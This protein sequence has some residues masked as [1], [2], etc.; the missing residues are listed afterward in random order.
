MLQMKIKA[1]R[2]NVLPGDLPAIL[3]A[4]RAY[5]EIG[6]MIDVLIAQMDLLAGDCDLEDDDNDCCSAREDDA[7]WFSGGG[8]MGL[9]NDHPSADDDWEMTYAEWHTLGGSR[10]RAGNFDGKPL[11]A[12]FGR[13]DHD[14]DEDSDP[15]GVFDEDDHSGWR[16]PPRGIAGAGCTISDPGGC[17][18]DGREPCE[19]AGDGRYGPDQSKGPINTAYVLLRHDLTERLR[20]YRAAGMTEMARRVTERI[21]AID[22]REGAAVARQSL[23]DAAAPNDA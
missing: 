20:D 10:R 16:S 2:R 5:R 23:L 1:G 4:Q 19:S 7:E 6:D 18:H 21:K 3:G 17:Q 22:E 9:I 13:M 8:E 15:A 11:E 14:D 12:N